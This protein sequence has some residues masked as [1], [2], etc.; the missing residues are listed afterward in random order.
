MWAA[1][2]QADIEAERQYPLREDL[3]Q[4]VADFA[5]LCRNGKVAVIVEDE[6]RRVD[7]MRETPPADYLLT[8]SDWL[9][10]R[11]TQEEMI[12]YPAGCAARLSALMA[13]LSGIK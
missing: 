6:P 1:L 10:L 9:P 13:S 3:P 11:I 7:E 2:K 4:Y 5:L 12:S 8:A